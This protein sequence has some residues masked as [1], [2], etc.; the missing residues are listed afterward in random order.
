MNVETELR[1][2]FN[3]LDD[4]QLPVN[5]DEI[6]ES[7]LPVRR[8]TDHR[9]RR[10]LALVAVGAAVAMIVLIWTALSLPDANR[11]VIDDP[12]PAPE[13]SDSAVPGLE[14]IGGTLADAGWRY[15]Q[16]PPV[17]LTDES[18]FLYRIAGGKWVAGQSHGCV[19]RECRIWTSLDLETWQPQE[20]G[21][22]EDGSIRTITASGGILWAVGHAELREADQWVAISHDGASWQPVEADLSA[23]GN[24]MADFDF[25]ELIVHHFG[26]GV[27]PYLVGRNDHILLVHPEGQP[28][29]STNGG[30][31]F[32]APEGV[33]DPIREW[34]FSWGWADEA[35]YHLAGPEF[36]ASS[37]DGA[38]WN[39]TERSGWFPFP[40]ENIYTLSDP[41]NA[42]ALSRRGLLD[43]PVI[44][45][46]ELVIVPMS[47]G[48]FAVSLDDGLSWLV[49]A[50]P[51][52]FEVD[53]IAVHRDPDTGTSWFIAFDVRTQTTWVSREAHLWF[54]TS[55]TLS[56]WRVA[57]P[58]DN[59][60]M[61]VPPH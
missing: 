54:S 50:D 16:S 27:Q 22:L 13:E 36:V 33:A 11:R 21:G 28:V 56:S 53:R 37:P 1:R 35:G 45:R 52:P 8:L 43:L 7:R 19:V 29:L 47:G 31:R 10:S 34:Q 12:L 51:Y 25:G 44:V 55:N 26:D 14:R 38:T 61:W 57:V 18:S 49:D 42:T 2:H 41:T 9:N 30:A 46:D 20:F 24:N 3:A 23:L 15:V 48:D 60:G 39:V 32:Q 5:I 17:D 59:Q 6:I 58:F 40:P 4:A